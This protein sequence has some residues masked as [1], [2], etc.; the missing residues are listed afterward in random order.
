M[1]TALNRALSELSPLGMLSLGGYF[2]IIRELSFSPA[3]LPNLRRLSLLRHCDLRCLYRLDCRRDDNSA[4]NQLPMLS[5]EQLWS[6]ASLPSLRSLRLEDWPTRTRL[7]DLSFL[8]QFPRLEHFDTQITAANVAS[9]ERALS[10]LKSLRALTHGTHGDELFGTVERVVLALATN[11]PQQLEHLGLPYFDIDRKGTSY[12]ELQARLPQLRSLNIGRRRGDYATN[13]K[14]DW[15][16]LG[17]MKQLEHLGVGRLSLDE[18]CS[19]V[20]A[21]KV[22]V[23]EN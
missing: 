21:C 7:K 12:L 4:E 10:Y 1:T 23:V 22:L 19:I 3:S 2:E 6:L 11:L 9:F 17:E 18:A 8:E 14:L 16:W 13:G 20:G 5:A 15:S